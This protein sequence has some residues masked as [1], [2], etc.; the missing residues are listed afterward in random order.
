MAGADAHG[1]LSQAE[2]A[3]GGGRGGER[4]GKSERERE[5]ERGSE[6][7]RA[8]EREFGQ[9]GRAS[10]CRCMCVCNCMPIRLEALH[11]PP[12]SPIA[13]ASELSKPDSGFRT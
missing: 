11:H 10:M 3:E 2:R 9:R 12:D 8:R 1:C 13:P 7:E 5:R 4:Q 6:R